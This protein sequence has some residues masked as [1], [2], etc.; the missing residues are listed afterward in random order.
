MGQTL[1][2]MS[3]QHSPRIVTN[4]LVLCLDA[5]NRDSYPG[6]GTVWTD[7]AGT[8]NGT[9]ENGPT[10]SS[11]NGGSIVFDGVDDYVYIDP[12]PTSLS[13][14]TDPFSIELWAYL[15][16]ENAQYFKTIL[17]I[18]TYEDGILFRHQPDN[19]AF[20]IAGTTWFWDCSVHMPQ[21]MW[22]HLT[23]T[24]D[25]SNIRLYVN[26]NLILFETNA[27]LDVTPVTPDSYLGASSHNTSELWPGY[28]STY[29]VYKNK[30]LTS[31][32]ILQNYNATKSRFF[33]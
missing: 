13:F 1:Q 33:L 19:D 15:S 26:G 20:Y 14:G 9:L 21:N 31:A 17:S 3:L 5:G 30:T 22:T 29:R 6:S 8:N 4:G 7:L 18:G 10:F 27:P 32:E 28:I 11:A 12:Q 25:G 23:I 24:K 16:D 2:Y